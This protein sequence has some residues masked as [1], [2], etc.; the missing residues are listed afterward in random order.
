MENSIFECNLLLI[1]SYHPQ[2]CIHL[3]LEYYQRSLS[4]VEEILELVENAN[5][6]NYN[7]IHG[8]SFYKYKFMKFLS[9]SALGMKPSYPWKGIIDATGGYI[10]VKENG[11]VLC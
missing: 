8:H 9:E 1:D 2:I 6:L 4:T 11:D 10:I 3:L 5:P 7:L